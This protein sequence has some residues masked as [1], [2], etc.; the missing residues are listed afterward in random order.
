MALHFLRVVTLF[1]LSPFALGFA[2]YQPEKLDVT[3][4]EGCI[5][6]LAANINCADYVRSFML[7]SYRG[8]LN[9]ITLTDTICTSDCLQ[10]LKG[11]YVKPLSLHIR[12]AKISGLC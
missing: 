8:S 1:L 6:A 7:L 10:S 12:C 4:G 2:I 9:N 5:G 3:L 11:W